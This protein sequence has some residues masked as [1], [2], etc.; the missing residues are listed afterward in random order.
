MTVRRVYALIHQDMRAVAIPLAGCVLIIACMVGISVRGSFGPFEIPFPVWLLFGMVTGAGIFARDRRT[1]IAPTL[2]SLPVSHLSRGLVRLV[3]RLFLVAV[4]ILV[5]IEIV[6][7]FDLLYWASGRTWASPNLAIQKLQQLYRNVPGMMKTALQAALIGF[8]PAAVFSTVVRREATAFGAAFLTLLTAMILFVAVMVLHTL[9]G[10]ASAALFNLFWLWTALVSAGAVIAIIRGLTLR[11]P[12]PRPALVRTIRPLAISVVVCGI[13]YAASPYYLLARAPLLMSEMTMAAAIPGSRDVIVEARGDLGD[14]DVSFGVWR[15]G[16]GR[17]NRLTDFSPIRVIV[18]PDGRLMAI[19]RPSL[20]VWVYRRP[21]LDIHDISGKLIRRESG[22]PITYDGEW[23]PDSRWFACP[24]LL[25]S[26]GGI[27]IIPASGEGPRVECRMNMP[28]SPAAYLQIPGIIGWLED[29]SVIAYSTRFIPDTGSLT[30]IVRIVPG[31]PA[32]LIWEGNL[33][34][35]KVNREMFRAATAL[36]PDRKSIIVPRWS[37][38]DSNWQPKTVSLLEIS[39]ETGVME[40]ITE[41][42]MATIGG[43]AGKRL[44]YWTDTQADTLSGNAGLVTEINVLETGSRMIRT[45]RVPHVIPD[46]MSPDGRWLA[47]HGTGGMDPKL[48]QLVIVELDTGVS[49]VMDRTVS[50]TLWLDDGSLA[51]ISG[52]KNELGIVDPATGDYQLIR[53]LRGGDR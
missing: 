41:M 32:T 12:E 22:Y 16:L 23:S 45:I 19:P 5:V 3:F 36:V 8:M 42:P 51:V 6:K 38:P 47:A 26:E 13:L 40:F 46:S 21:V 4:T 20:H 29:G 37:G 9:Q 28:D 11:E 7:Q 15:M 49:R 48:A 34:P 25:G 44:I 33:W 2:Q 17:M 27:F 24:G 30:R 50:S 18:S 53:K 10:L 14:S 39:I 43:D 35:Y 1:G 31:E 52:M